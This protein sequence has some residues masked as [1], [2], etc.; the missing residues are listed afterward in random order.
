MIN[1]F[2]YYFKDYMTE[3]TFFEEHLFLALRNIC[4]NIMSTSLVSR[5]PASVLKMY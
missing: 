5:D 1:D 3:R 2:D 4:Q